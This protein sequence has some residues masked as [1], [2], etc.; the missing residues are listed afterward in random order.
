M[1]PLYESSQDL[2]NEAAVALE[3]SKRWKCHFD[4]LPIKY[5]VDYAVTK[6]AD[7]VA[8]AEIKCRNYSYSQID[9]MGGYMISAHKWVMGATFADSMNIPLILI[10]KLT[11][12]IWWTKE[13]SK[14]LVLS[15]R[16]DRNDPQDIEPCI[17][18]PMSAFQRG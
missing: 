4:K 10:V 2:Q 5:N 17:L 1:R 13:R 18:I 3:M 16:K 15:G 7:I 8:L 11:D 14:K 9:K 12:G 6:G